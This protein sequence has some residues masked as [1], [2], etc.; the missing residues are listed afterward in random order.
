[1]HYEKYSACVPETNFQYFQIWTITWIYYFRF[2]CSVTSVQCFVCELFIIFVK[3]DWAI[4]CEDMAFSA[5]LARLQLVVRYTIQLYIYNQRILEVLNITDQLL[6]GSI[7]MV[8]SP[9]I[10]FLLSTFP[11]NVIVIVLSKTF[12]SCCCFSSSLRR[13]VAESDSRA[14]SV[15][16][17]AAASPL[18]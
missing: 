11:L 13:A 17:A 7:L 8:M 6:S 4:C 12:S 9:A 15:A 3:S 1:M 2:R 16:A 5:A 10:P 18:R 14:L